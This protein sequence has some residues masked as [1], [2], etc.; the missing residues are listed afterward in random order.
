MGGYI[1]ARLLVMLESVSVVSDC[2]PLSKRPR[3]SSG[4]IM[5]LTPSTFLPAVS[6]PDLGCGGYQQHNQ[7]AH[8]QHHQYAYHQSTGVPPY[9]SMLGGMGLPS[10]SPS[11]LSS[12]DVHSSIGQF[13]THLDL[14]DVDELC[15]E[16]GHNNGAS[17]G[18]SG[19]SAEFHLPQHLANNTLNQLQQHHH[20]MLYSSTDKGARVVGVDGAHSPHVGVDEFAHGHFDTPQSSRSGGSGSDFSDA[21]VG[22][23]VGLMA[24]PDMELC[25][26]QF[27]HSNVSHHDQHQFQVPWS[28]SHNHHRSES[29]GP[30]ALPS[31]S[32]SLSGD[33]SSHVSSPYGGSQGAKSL[34]AAVQ[35]Q[36]Q[37]QY[38]KFESSVP[39]AAMGTVAHLEQKH[40]QAGGPGGLG[41]SPA[42]GGAGGMMMMMMGG[43]GATGGY[44]VR[45]S[46]ELPQISIAF[47]PHQLARLSSSPALIDQL[48]LPPPSSVVPR[49]SLA[50]STRS[51][52]NSLNNNNNNTR[53]H[54]ANNSHHSSHLAEFDLGSPE[55]GEEEE[56]LSPVPRKKQAARRSAASNSSAKA[57]T[58]ANNNKSNAKL[59]RRFCHICRSPKDLSRIVTCGS[60]KQSHVFCSSCVQRRLD[61]NFEELL[62]RRD[63]LCPKCHNR[64]PCSKCR[65]KRA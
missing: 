11:L 1:S 49:I 3:L 45:S 44:T 22:C 24:Q 10:C 5:E 57:N 20:G 61:L 30:N 12:F 15:F 25:G 26:N 9:G 65:P 52:S 8:P 48:E 43:S 51:H 35:H 59:T 19:T 37:Q 33:R 64:C 39:H 38:E 62:R 16:Y 32:S 17:L 55:S 6:E 13:E 53:H 36:H 4:E 34:L 28:K 56:A 42:G 50:A 14:H 27:N 29:H 2:E 7:H 21:G 63:W 47:S 54:N 58:G 18:L 46:A 23:G 60:G 40:H 41:S 31:L